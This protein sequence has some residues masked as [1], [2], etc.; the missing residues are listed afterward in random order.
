MPL[1]PVTL[2]GGATANA[3]ITTDAS[4]P[5]FGARTTGDA[6][7]DTTDTTHVAYWSSLFLGHRI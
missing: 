1:G 5:T 2:V 3:Y 6:V 4:R 7:M